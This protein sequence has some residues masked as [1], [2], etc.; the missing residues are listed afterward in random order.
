MTIL[1]PP[2][3]DAILNPLWKRKLDYT[4]ISLS[5]KRSVHTAIFTVSLEKGEC[6]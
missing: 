3:I 4:F 5:V 1:T 6:S 2:P